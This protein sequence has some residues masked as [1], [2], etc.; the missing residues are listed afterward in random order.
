[1]LTAISQVQ[2][3][4]NNTPGHGVYA[5]DEVKTTFRLMGVLRSLNLIKSS[6]L[7]EATKRNRVAMMVI[8]R[9][10]DEP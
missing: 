10:S 3:W 5:P 7:R 8:K 4:G 1:M 9:L 2:L 6:T